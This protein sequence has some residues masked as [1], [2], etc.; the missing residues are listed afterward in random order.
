MRNI[1]F[2]RFF[3]LFLA[4]AIA[5]GSA[6]SVPAQSKKDR[7]RAR[8]IAQQGDVLFNQKDYRGA[9]GKYAEAIVVFPGFAV[10]HYWKAFAHY[11]LKENDQALTDFD[12]AIAKGYEKPLEIYRVRWLIYFDKGDFDAALRDANELVRAE[13]KNAFNHFAVGS[14]YQAK[15]EYPEAIAS[16]KKGLQFRANEA[17]VH[18]RLAECYAQTGDYLSQGFSALD[19]L[20]YKTRFVGESSFYVADALYRAKKYDEAIDYYERTISLKPELYASYIPLADIYRI[21]NRFKDAV[22]TSK[23]GIAQFPLDVNL[24]IGLSWYY[25]L[26]DMPQDAVVAAQSAIKIDPKQSMGYTNLCRAQ[27]DLKQYSAAIQSCNSALRLNPGDGESHLY[28]ARSYEF[29]N[30]TDRAV[31]NYNKAITGLIK[32]TQDN[33]EYSDGFYLLGT[34]Y[35]ALQK[36]QEAVDALLACLR[37]APNFARARYVLGY[38]YYSMGN[39]TAAREQY[40]L[41]LGIDQALAEKLRAVI[42]K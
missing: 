11:Y 9:I 29:L 35:F 27:N 6:A 12:A 10:A 1:K 32:Y 37:L 2:V 36:D 7:E 25:S 41:L 19:A 18:Y 22:A 15:K 16:Y 5:L 17:D 28:L 40:N 21:K 4:L 42:E 24:W 13:S 38:S 14:I 30:Q 34:A 3:G 20:K 39:K 33:P 31:D 8:K 23:K 26:A